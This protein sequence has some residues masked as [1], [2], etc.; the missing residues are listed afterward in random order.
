VPARWCSVVGVGIGMLS[1]DWRADAS[2]R[3][4]ERATARG[5]PHDVR[6]SFLGLGGGLRFGEV[7]GQI[8]S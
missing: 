6:R 2:G 5:K 3:P 4:D 7:C 1:F 8:K